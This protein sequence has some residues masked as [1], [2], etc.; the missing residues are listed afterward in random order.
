MIQR[1][2]YES[3]DGSQPQASSTIPT[4]GSPATA[5]PT[6]SASPT[7]QDTYSPYSQ[8]HDAP[9]ALPQYPA[10]TKSPVA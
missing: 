6:T 8:H 5:F 9:P 7:Y 1:K 10:E 3:I 4:V 2:S